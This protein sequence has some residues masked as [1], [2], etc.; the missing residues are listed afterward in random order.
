M[1]DP[2]RPLGGT[3]AVVTGASRGIGA[4]TA[5]ALEAAGAHVIGLAR[6]LAHGSA[7]GRTDRPC[8]VT[9]EAGLREVATEMLALH[10]PPHL[11]VSNAGAFQMAPLEDTGVA[12]L[13]AQLAAN[14]VGP[15][16]VA[17]AFLPAMR[18]AGRGR[19]LLVGSIADHRGFPGN[20][21]YG[22]SKF[23]ARGL[24][25][26]LRAEFQGT[27]VLCTLVSPGP[28]NTELWDAV[29]PDRREGFIPRRSMLRPRDVAEA[30]LFVATRPPHV[31]M[32]WV[33]IDPSA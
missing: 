5:A 30:I 12:D 18:S 20:T 25:E 2:A 21:A 9:D 10:G 16:T 27:G 26:A 28:T 29:D 7:A 17:R 33:R 24:H 8:D 19:H 4:A 32:D 23:G 15:F 13:E 22:A 6:S 1:S 14:V 31:D 3:V 11:V